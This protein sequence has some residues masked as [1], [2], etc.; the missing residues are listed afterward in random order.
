MAKVLLPDA[1]EVTLAE[2]TAKEPEGRLIAK[3]L[4]T[5]PV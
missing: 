1:I 5:P 3:L 4:K 2:L